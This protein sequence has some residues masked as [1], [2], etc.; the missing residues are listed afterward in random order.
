VELLIAAESPINA[1]DVDGLTP[2]HLVARNGHW[3]CIAPLTGDGN[4]DQTLRTKHTNRTALHMAAACDYSE[5]VERLLQAGSDRTLLPVSCPVAHPTPPG[6]ARDAQ[7]RTPLHLA[8]QSG[9]NDSVDLLAKNTD[10]NAVDNQVR[11]PT[12][13]ALAYL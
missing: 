2:L 11:Q 4:A 8:A 3:E 1:A 7:G 13:L 5:C 9:S 6:N 12:S 10:V